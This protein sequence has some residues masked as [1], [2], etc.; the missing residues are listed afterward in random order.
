M[1]LVRSSEGQCLRCSPM[2]CTNVIA[3]LVR[4][5]ANT[6]Q[7]GDWRGTGRAMSK[8]T[9]V[10]YGFWWDVRYPFS[11]LRCSGFAKGLLL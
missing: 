11:H 10:R 6:R 3:A 1:M 2:N 9:L 5:A 8:Q 4:L 7:L